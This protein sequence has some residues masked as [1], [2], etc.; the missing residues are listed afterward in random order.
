MSKTTHKSKTPPDM[1]AML[2]D[3]VAWIESALR[4]NPHYLPPAWVK[5]W[6]AIRAALTGDPWHPM[7]SAPKDGTKVLICDADQG[8]VWAAW[9][10]YGKVYFE[11]WVYGWIVPYS[12]DHDMGGAQVIEKPLCW[13][14]VPEGPAKAGRND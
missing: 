7:S 13:M 10:E 4:A 3:S 1:L 6:P 8:V 2:D 5:Q 14:H 9:E 12:E 11:G